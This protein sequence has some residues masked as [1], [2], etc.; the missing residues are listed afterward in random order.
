MEYTSFNG[1]T[2]LDPQQGKEFTSLGFDGIII[3]GLPVLPK[4]YIYLPSGGIVFSGV[5]ATSNEKKYTYTPGGG[6]QLSGSATTTYIKFVPFLPLYDF[7]L[8]VSKS[9]LFFSMS[10]T[11]IFINKSKSIIYFT[12]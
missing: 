1:V 6:I 3:N 10:R 11:S 8:S 4:T 7:G 9:S 2:I 5:A 12:K